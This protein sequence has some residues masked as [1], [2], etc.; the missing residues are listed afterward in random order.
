MANYCT[1]TTVEQWNE[2]FRASAEK[3]LLVF[4]HSTRCPISAGAYEEWG[5]W[6]EDSA[7]LGIGHVLVRVIEERPVSNAIEEATGVK[8]ASPQVILVKDG[9]AVWNTSHWNITYSS[10]DEQVRQHCG[11]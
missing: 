5:K 2:A 3:P 6:L 4:K 8:H 11:K 10:L 7:D 1:L 9:K